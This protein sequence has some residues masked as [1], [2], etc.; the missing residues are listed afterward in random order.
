MSK[1]VGEAKKSMRSSGLVQPLADSM[2]P[3]LDGATRKR[4]S[5]IRGI[6]TDIRVYRGLISVGRANHILGSGVESITEHVE[7]LLWC[8]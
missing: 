3:H 4:T 5:P 7:R 2:A 1:H 6:K 8:S